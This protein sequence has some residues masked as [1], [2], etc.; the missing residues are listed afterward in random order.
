MPTVKNIDSLKYFLNRFPTI[1]SGYQYLVNYHK[2]VDPHFESLPT[3]IAEFFDCKTHS[4]PLLLTNENHL[5]TNH[6]WNLTHKSR[7]KPGKTHGLWQKW[8]DHVEMNLPPVTKQFNETYTYVWLPIDKDSADN[9]WHVW[10]DVISKFRL[11]EKRWSTNFTKYIFI[12]SN[13]SKYFDKITKE[14]FPELKYMV[15]PKNE[16]WQ[17]KHLIVPS[18]SNYKDGVIT[19]H[20]APWLRRL[21]KTL[22]IGS[23][24]KRKIFISR[25]G[26]KTRKLLNAEKLMIALKGWETVMLETLSIKDQV[27]CF[28]EASHVVST[29]G[30]GLANLLWCEPGTKV[31]EIQD[32]NM[33]KKKVYPVV[34][35]HLGLD[36]K[37]YLAKII[38]IKIQGAKLKGVKRLNDLINFE[39]DIID[40]IKHLD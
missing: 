39:V 28:S 40:F 34:S 25:E 35:Y 5:I 14:F 4:C 23:G 12:L 21:K 37:L 22:K 18:L 38:P 24:R 13:P 2:S 10:I 31:I 36:H 11:I 3:F 32:P 29:H 26:A 6:V 33:L 19:P 7:N 15:M 9:P 27:R 8:G 17:F 1:D 20:L 16:T 30:A